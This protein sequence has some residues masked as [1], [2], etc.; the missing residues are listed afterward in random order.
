VLLR[1][2]RQRRRRSLAAAHV[3]LFL[4]VDQRPS[5]RQIRPH[6]LNIYP[7]LLLLMLMLLVAK[8]HLILTLVTAAA[9][10]LTEAC[11]VGHAP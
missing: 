8:V 4:G 7:L 9:D 11:C 6:I 10:V 1:R 5:P 2:R 3:V